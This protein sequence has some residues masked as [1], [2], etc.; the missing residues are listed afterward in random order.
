M[1]KYTRE[2]RTR[3]WEFRTKVITYKCGCQIRLHK[4][5]PS[6][7]P[8]VCEEHLEPIVEIENVT[9]LVGS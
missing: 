9:R 4:W 7:V 3:T 6:S 1:T 8:M 5:G 2:G